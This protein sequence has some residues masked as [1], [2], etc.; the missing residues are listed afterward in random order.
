M[1]SRRVTFLILAAWAATLGWFG[2]REVWPLLF[3]GES[4]PFIIELAD[5]VTSEFGGKNRS[6]DVLW[7]IFLGDK[8]I[9]KAETRLAYHAKQNIFE[10]ETRLAEVKLMAWITMP[11][12][13][14]T[15]HLTREGELR[16]IVVDG[17]MRIL[18]QEA[19]GTFTGTVRDGQVHRAVKL[20]I[21]LVGTVEPALEPVPA[22]V[23][24]ILNPMH[25]VPRIKGLQPGRT[26]RQPIIN[27][28]GDAIQPAMTAIFQKLGAKAPA[29]KLPSGP[30][31][32]DAEVLTATKVVNV[33]QIDYE[34]RVIEYRSP[35]G[36]S[37]EPARTFVRISDGAVL[38][39]EAQSMGQRIVLQRE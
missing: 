12:M 35:Q 21:P 32:V 30:E 1:P 33:N 5:E 28:I 31:Y 3:P 19:K 8:R 6:P 7:G 11:E 22:P 17:R 16:G 27:P 14:S 15:Y 25:P 39:Q 23:G 36:A 4:P 26:W 24:S 37:E 38:R 10:L 20:N 2:Y 29:L 13:I 18:E 9:G 34:C